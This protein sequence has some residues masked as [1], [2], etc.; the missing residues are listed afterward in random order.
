MEGLPYFFIFNLIRGMMITIILG[1]FVG[2]MALLVAYFI[3]IRIQKEERRHLST[4][5]GNVFMR[6]LFSVPNRKP[7]TEQ[8]IWIRKRRTPL[9]KRVLGLAELGYDT[10]CIKGYKILKSKRYR[11]KKNSL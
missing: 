8:V 7:D 2:F 6:D 9:E 1:C 11:K 5:L 10:I 4:S 3:D